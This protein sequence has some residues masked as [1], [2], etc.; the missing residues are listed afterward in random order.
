MIDIQKKNAT[1][2]KPV[3]TQRSTE[4]LWAKKICKTAIL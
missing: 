1:Q 4:R 2:P 3:S